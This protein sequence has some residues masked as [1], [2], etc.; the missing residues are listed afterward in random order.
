MSLIGKMDLSDFFEGRIGRGRIILMKYGPGSGGETL[1]KEFISS[2]PQGMNAVY[3]SSMES[4]EELRSGILTQNGKVELVSLL[5]PLETESNRTV[6]RDRFSS[7][8]I[9]VTDLLEISMADRPRKDTEVDMLSPVTRAA[10]KQVMPFRF[11]LDSLPDIITRGAEEDIIPRLM[12]L[13]R[14]V[15]SVQGNALIG[16]PLEW[17]GLR[18]RET[19]IFDCLLEARAVKGL[20]GYERRLSLTHLRNDV[21]PPDEW[22]VNIKA[23]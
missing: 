2:T 10:L 1:I 6:R 17:M 21:Q 14:A 8:G 9:L 7:E 16:A 5:G 19:S 20:T 15:R 4:E 18:D 13:R 3:I 12:T 11:G 22:S 23:R